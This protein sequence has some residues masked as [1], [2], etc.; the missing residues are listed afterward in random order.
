MHRFARKSQIHNLNEYST[1]ETGSSSYAGVASQR[2]IH[3]EQES[4]SKLDR[5]APFKL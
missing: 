4:R 1:V 5:P 3:L 2:Y